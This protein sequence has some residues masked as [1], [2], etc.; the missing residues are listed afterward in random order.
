MAAE[1]E[2][3]VP[4]RSYP[5]KYPLTTIGG[6]VIFEISGPSEG[7]RA[8]NFGN[9]TAFT[10][11]LL[12][13][14]RSDDIVFDIGACV[15]VVALFA[16]KKVSQVFAFE[17]DPF[18]ASRLQNNININQLAN[19]Q[20]IPWAI[21]NEDGIVNFYTSGRAGDHSPSLAPLAYTKSV[22]V[23]ARALDPAIQSGALP[24]PTAIK[25]DI[26][27]AEYAALCGMNALLISEQAP[28]IIF[29]E[30]HPD[31]LPK[32][33]AS[34]KN[35]MD[36]LVG[37]GYRISYRQQR[38]NQYHL[39]LE[40]NPERAVTTRQRTI[41][42]TPSNDT[43][44]NW[45]LPIAAGFG[46][47]GDETRSQFMIF[48]KRQEHAPETL[49]SHAIT[50]YHYAP[51]LLRTIAPT[52]I[53]LGNDW[54]PDKSTL[55]SEA[56]LLKIPTICIQEGPLLFDPLQKQLGHADFALLQGPVMKKYVEN[57]QAIIV[58][59][60]KYDR[61]R[62]ANIPTKP[63]VMINCNFTY[64][65]YEDQ[66]EAW[67]EAAVSA[68]QELGLD[69]FV[70]QHPRDK[71]VLPEAYP[72]V[73]S[74]AASIPGQLQETTILV[75]RFS[76]LVY[77]ALILGRQVV[78]FDPMN[79]P[80]P[81]IKENNNG[82]VFYAQNSSD[83]KSCLQAASAPPAE[84]AR[85]V[86]QFL[87]DHCSDGG[88]VQ[89][90]IQ[91]IH[92]IAIQAQAIQTIGETTDQSP[93]VDLSTYQSFCDLAA[94]LDHQQRLTANLWNATQDLRA[95]NQWLDSQRQ[96]WELTAKG[97]QE[98]VETLE[99]E[100]VDWRYLGLVQFLQRYTRRRLGRVKQKFGFHK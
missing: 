74:N 56:R 21:S 40:K 41:L 16:A 57:P 70:S 32:F 10:Q 92:N 52:V 33:G 66:R 4:N 91:A 94:E 63:R 20:V 45:M 59:N 42:F 43:H 26:E 46:N 6:Q 95:G 50:Y 47:A 67:V 85:L 96:T 83:L 14:L 28:R 22:E 97:R 23:Q 82:A 62:T 55:I 7:V 60:P 73:R 24:A 54:G 77:E 86:E 13:N 90:C 87:E 25:I 49:D 98:Y 100:I 3:V 53:V 75:T 78:Y 68:C 36:V 71:G 29:I 17:P 72:V 84:H 64:G 27:G 48:P 31:F 8:I 93:P 79:E 15:G 18:Y 39:I 2:P 35:V 58:G 76:T 34:I 30:I 5:S 65:V 61:H 9:E 51:G 69:F 11:I 37:A 38:A 44:A 89:K 80:Y 99:N 88:A 81:V 12:E 1:N 19:I